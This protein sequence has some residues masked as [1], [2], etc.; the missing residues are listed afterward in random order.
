[1]WEWHI[2]GARWTFK[3]NRSQKDRHFLSASPS[4]LSPRFKKV[5]EWYEHSSTVYQQGAVEWSLL[6]SLF[7]GVLY[8]WKELKT[9]YVSEEVTITA[10]LQ[11]KRDSWETEESVYCSNN[12]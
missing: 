10:Q 8:L 11:D 4:V 5:D 7:H 3:L 12:A 9:E 1:M 6:W 2:E